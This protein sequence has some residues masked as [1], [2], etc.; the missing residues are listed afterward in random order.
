MLQTILITILVAVVIIS[1]GWRELLRWEDRHPIED[2]FWN[3]L[4]RR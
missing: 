3:R 2:D 4:A 1:L